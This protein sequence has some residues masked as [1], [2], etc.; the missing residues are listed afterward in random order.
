M[1]YHN[2]FNWFSRQPNVALVSDDNRQWSVQPAGEINLEFQFE[3]KPPVAWFPSQKEA[4][5]HYYSETEG[6]EELPELKRAVDA[7]IQHM[8]DKKVS[9]EL[10]W[11]YRCDGLD[12]KQIQSVLEDPD[13][14][15]EIENELLDMNWECLADQ[16]KDMADGI[17]RDLSLGDDHPCL[18]FLEQYAWD[19]MEEKIYDDVN[20]GD[21]ISRTSAWGFT[22]QVEGAETQMQGW[23]GIR[24][25]EEVERICEVLNVSPHHLQ[26]LVTEEGLIL[27]TIP[28]REGEECIP[29]QDLKDIY[30]NSIYGGVLCFMITLDLQAWALN[31]DK[32]LAEEHGLV[33][34]KGTRVVIHDYLNGATGGEGLLSKDLTLTPGTFTMGYDR[35][36]NYGIQSCCGYTREAW[37]GTIRANTPKNEN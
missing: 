26:D 10:Y 4:L 25:L 7:A 23:Q 6:L 8:V 35:A 33:I 27:P 31:G 24:D 11:D 32:E 9:N 20:I 28:E 13:G 29:I 1:H 34:E 37:D 30:I 17:I 21:L 12:E 5:L 3:E 15:D 14:L 2:L 36:R 16:R 19:A 22:I 18:E